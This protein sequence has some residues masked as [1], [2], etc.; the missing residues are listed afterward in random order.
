MKF[1]FIE[2]TPLRVRVFF[3]GKAIAS[4]HRKKFSVSSVSYDAVIRRLR[5]KFG[6]EKIRVGFLVNEQAKWSYQSLYEEFEKSEEFSPVV[7]I[8][9]MAGSHYGKLKHVK[10]ISE[11]AAFFSSLG[12]RTQLAYDVEKKRYI[13]PADLGID[14]LFYQQPWE[15]HDIQAPLSVAS[16]MLTC[17]TSYGME[18]TLYESSYMDKFHGAIWK[19]FVE[20]EWII[21]YFYQMTKKHVSNCQAVG[22][23]KLDT[24]FDERPQLPI[25]KEIV[26]YAPHHSLEDDS[27]RCAT[28][29]HTGMEMLAFAQR[30]KEHFYWIFKPHPR[31]KSHVIANGILSEKEFAAYYQAWSELGEVYEG[32]DYIPLFKQSSALIT[33]SI[34]FLGEYLPSGHPVFQFVNDIETF[35]DWGREIIATYYQ[36]KN[37]AEME[38]D[39]N[40]VIFQRDDYLKEKRL[41]MINTVLDPKE[42]TCKKIVNALRKAIKAD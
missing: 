42:T 15:V 12:L 11:C 17:Y 8:T 23:V 3:G 13:H 34:S 10:S 35:N 2:R 27:L 41:S 21:S 6:K 37:V 28:F 20:N 36:A 32:G 33:D 31:F 30:Y 25:Q 22:Y 24:Y 16:D 18:L 9:E 40:R 4:F 29:K 19:I 14:I 26:I 39:F 5:E 38:K 7:L 1:F